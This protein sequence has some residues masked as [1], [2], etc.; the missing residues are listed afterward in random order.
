MS[1]RK[2]STSSLDEVSAV[3]CEMIARMEDTAELLEGYA[4]HKGQ[5][6]RAEA[7]MHAAQLRRAVHEFLVL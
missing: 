2:C 6:M 1:C 3:V 4:E 5:I 7:S